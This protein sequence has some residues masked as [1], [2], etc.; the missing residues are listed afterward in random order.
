MLLRRTFYQ[1]NILP[2]FHVYKLYYLIL[3]SN[4]YFFFLWHLLT[5]GTNGEEKVTVKGV[6]DQS[7]SLPC[8]I[9]EIN[10]GAIYFLTWSKL[11][12]DERW[13]R[14]YVYSDDNV[15]KPLSS[16]AGRARFT[17]QKSEAQLVINSLKPSDE[18]L[19]KVS[20]MKDIYYTY[21]YKYILISWQNAI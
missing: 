12:R 3:L 4:Y 18:A 8:Y 9:D 19:Y 10:C 20:A 14:I 5:G 1:S 16:L 17:M 6:A 11:E 21:I 13:S 15:N 2:I 7:A